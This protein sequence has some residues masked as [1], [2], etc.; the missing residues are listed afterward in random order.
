M[1]TDVIMP[2]MGESIAEG[3][4][5]KWLV[6]VGDRIERDQP[7]FEI[8]TD[9]V[10]AEI[11]SPADG[12]LLEVKFDEGAT[13]PV[14]E[15]VAMLGEPGEESA[16]AEP[17]AEPAAEPALAEP[18]ATEAAAAESEAPAPP[19]PAEA[20]AAPPA[21][22]GA[23]SEE[24]ERVRRF[25]SPVV[26]KMAAEH[27]IDLAAV[28]GTG[29][30]GRVTRRDLEQF[31]SSGGAAAAP[32]PASAPAPKP[33]P[34]PAPTPAAAPAPAAGAPHGGYSV[35]AYG[36]GDD[37]EVVPMTKIRQITAAHMVYSKQ[38]SAHVTTVLPTAVSVPVTKRPLTPRTSS[39]GGDLVGDGVGQRVHG[40]DGMGRHGR[41]AQAGRA[42]RH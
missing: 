6:K 36:A 14:D 19:A 7:L 8:S 40:L 18:A 4:I 23:A 33:A 13:V 38:T 41:D 16:V 12:V 29:I 25:S 31:M 26:R 10:D 24:S 22:S 2:Q 9:K 5:T 28:I 42:F 34:A 30:H 21:P 32:A 15:V 20:P 39:Q 35:A 37:V 1:A 17:P 27:G 11:P 3:T